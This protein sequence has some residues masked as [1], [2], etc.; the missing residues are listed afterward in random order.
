MSSNKSKAPFKVV[1]LCSEW[2][3]SFFWGRMKD[4]FNSIM[5]YPLPY[6][7]KGEVCTVVGGDDTYYQLKEYPEDTW[8]KIEFRRISPKN[9]E[10]E[11]EE[12]VFSAYPETLEVLDNP[13]KEKVN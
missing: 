10:V 3:S 6:P 8:H 13:V 5:G 2:E 9:T 7:K 12:S 11:I 1:C 4:L